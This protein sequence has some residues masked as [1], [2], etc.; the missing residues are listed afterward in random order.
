MKDGP[1][2]R[3]VHPPK[4]ML[5]G[6]V[7]SSLRSPCSV[8]PSPGSSCRRYP[9]HVP[10][11]PASFVHSSP[12]PAEPDRFASEPGPSGDMMTE[13]ERDRRDRRVKGTGGGRLRPSFCPSFLRSFTRHATRP[14]GVH[15]VSPSSLGL[16]YGSRRS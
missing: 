13:E 6:P 11:Q 1:F 14:P 10:S 5:K 8:G 2:T 16:A 12:Y 7:C 3:H 4:G 15:L 9:P